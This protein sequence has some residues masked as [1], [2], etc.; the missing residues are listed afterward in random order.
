[1][2]EFDQL[3]MRHGECWLQGIVEQIERNEGIASSTAATLE[4]RWN[5]LM[6]APNVQSLPSAA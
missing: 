4:E 5:A 6:R 1:M 2:P 3:L